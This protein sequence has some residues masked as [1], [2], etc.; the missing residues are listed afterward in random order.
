MEVMR[1]EQRP[2]RSY[3]LWWLCPEWPSAWQTSG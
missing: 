1:V 3:L 2:G